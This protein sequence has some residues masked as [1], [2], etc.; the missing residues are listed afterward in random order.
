MALEDKLQSPPFS[1]KPFPPFSPEDEKKAQ[2]ELARLRKK[3]NGS[4][5]PLQWAH[6]IFSYTLKW[7]GLEGKTLWDWVQLL[8]VPILLASAT[9]GFSIVQQQNV[10]DQQR[11]TT[12]QTYIDNIQELLLKDNLFGDNPAPKNDA[13]KVMIQEVLELA[14]ARTLTAVQGLD[15]DR[16][17]RLVQFLYEAQLIGFAEVDQHRNLKLHRQIIDLSGA[18]LSNANLSNANLDSTNLDNAGLDGANLS[19]ANLDSTSFYY[20]NLSGAN[21]SNANLS[22]ANP[23]FADLSG[24]N[25]SHAKLDGARLYYANLSGARLYYANLSGANLGHANLSGADL[26]HANLTVADLSH[27][28]LSGAELGDAN[29][30]YA[31]NLTQEQ[32]DQVFSC[33]GAILPTGL[34]CR[35]N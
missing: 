25:L 18:D 19:N 5:T 20:A 22:N 2:K 9:I 24:A 26:G 21:L 12:L 35:K 16:K 34:T 31:N 27:A 30:T 32:L 29:L 33:Q 15:P 4:R 8:G 10:L 23:Y 13:D 7:T 6:D 11:A 17:G 14:R 28:N 3:E 1:P